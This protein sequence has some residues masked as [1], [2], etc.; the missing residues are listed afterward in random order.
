MSPAED[1]VVVLPPEVRPFEE[2]SLFNPAF[3]ALI[4]HSS[5]KD[6]EARSTR[7]LPIVLAYLVA[8]LALHR[9]TREALPS[10]VTSQMGEW[11]RAHPV[12]LLELPNRS[13]ALRPLVSAGIRFGLRHRVL[14]SEDGRLFSGD[15]RRRPRNLPR[16]TDV[17]DCLACAAFLGRWFSE[18]PDPVTTLALWGLRP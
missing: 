2:E 13:R 18:Q 9:P 14:R 8:P 15:L 6:H 5:S 16:S 1:S 3:L 11:I 10:N 7:G 12:L 17:E 4:Y